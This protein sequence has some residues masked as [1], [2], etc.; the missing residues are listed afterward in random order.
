MTATP[1]AIA[2][3]EHHA[4][5]E[6]HARMER[7]A[8]MALGHAPGRTGPAA[9]TKP[10]APADAAAATPA[11]LA[12]AATGR[13]TT[14]KRPSARRRLYRRH[15]VIRMTSDR[16]L[17]IAIAM[18]V[19]L[20]AG[21]S[22]APG[23]APVGANQV[24]ALDDA[25]APRLA[26][27]GGANGFE[28]FDGPAADEELAAAGIPVDDGTLYKPVAVDTSVKTSAGMLQHYTVKDGDTLT[29]IANRF[30]VSMMTVWW[31]NDLTL[32]DQKELKAGRE[33]TIPPVSG[34]VATVE[35]G[36]TL[37]SI[38]AA[39]KVELEDIIQSNQL[40]DPNLI[41]GQVLLIPGAK[42]DPMPTPEPTPKP[43]PK[44]RSGGGGGGFVPTSGS[45]AWPVP[46]GYVSQY[47]HYGHY[48]VDV[49]ADY[50]SSIVSPRAGEVVFA[51]WKSNGGGYQVWIYHGNG[52]YSGHH[53]M[54]SVL[55]ST[56][57]SVAKGQRIGR[58]GSSGW[59]TGPHDHFEV[60]VGYPWKSG[61]YRVNAL[62]YY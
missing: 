24:A 13:A 41:V 23:A 28:E 47:F 11:P 30:G 27:G 21:V 57:Q 50:G 49:A 31:A 34:L 48:G 52:I 14:R 18:I 60:W 35:A 46:S 45:W 44:P 8:A 5:A 10:A 53:H 19:V 61:S 42:G 33:L 55:V 2:R 4:R 25:A 20:A 17:P 6:R 26:V 43:T 3:A 59:A 37:E 16:A 1:R 58:V 38:A 51:G 15:M 29:A 22:L 54:S 7:E 9:F 56:G 39:N 12:R 62:R 32:E 40:D 36:D